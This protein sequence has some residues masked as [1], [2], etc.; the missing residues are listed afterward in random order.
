[1]NQNSENQE[2]DNPVSLI[3]G[4]SAAQKVPGNGPLVAGKRL[5]HG[6]W[7]HL[8]GG[9]MVLQGCSP[10]KSPSVSWG[11]GLQN[12]KGGLVPCKA[13]EALPGIHGCCQQGLGQLG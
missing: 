11:G 9:R 10:R 8:H 1:M 13:P 12:M 4:D 3:F 2:K 6:L 7:G 5:S